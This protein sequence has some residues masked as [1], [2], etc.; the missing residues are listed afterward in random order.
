MTLDNLRQ[1]LGYALRGIRARPAFAAAVTV[2]LA[3]GIGANAAMFGIVDRLLFRP[4]PLLHD[5][6]TTHR[7][8]T[9]RQFR[10]SERPGGVSQYARYLGLV[11]WTTSFS[12]TAG[13]SVG[14]M[15]VGVGEAAREMQIGRVS[16]GFFGFFDAAPALGRFFTDAEDQPPAGTPVAVLGYTFWRTRYGGSRDVL[17]SVVQIGPTQYTII[18]VAPREFVGLWADRPPAAYIP[19]TS[20]AGASGV[21]LGNVNWWETY[22]WGWMNMIARRKPGVPVEAANADLSQALIKTYAAQRIEQPGTGPD[23]IL[24]PRAIAGSILAERGPT[25]SPTARVATWVG[26]VSVIVLLIACAN[27]ANLLL[28]RALHRRREIALRLA[29]GVSRARLVSQLLI[30]SVVLALMGGAAGILVAHWGGA[31]LRA[32]LLGSE[33]SGGLSDPRTVLFAAVAALAVGVLAGLAPV[34]Q[35]TRSDLAGDLKAGVREGT[36]GRSRTRV[37]LL[38]VQSALSVVLLIGAGL[39]V[40][41]LR[42]VRLV[43]LGF[44]TEPVVM[45]DLAMRGVRLDSAAYVALRGRLLEAAR[46]IPGVEN[47]SLRAAVPFWSSWSFGAPR[48]A[49]V[50]STNRFGQFDLNPVSAEHFATVG[51]RIL[52]GRG[53]EPSDVAGAPLAAVVSA[54]MA[55]VLWPGKDPLGE[56]MRIGSDTV[57]CTYVVGVAEDIKTRTLSPDSTFYYYLSVQQ[58]NPHIGGLFVRTAG[59]AGPM[60]ETVRKRLQQEMPGASYV[61]V[62]PMTDI[63]GPQMRSWRLGAT[64]FVAFGLLALVVAGVG[65]YSVIAY[66]VQQ[67]THELGVRMALGADAR[68]VARLVLL[69]GLRFAAFGVAAGAGLALLGGRYVADLLF[70]VSPRDPFVFIAVTATLGAVA[71]AA[72]WIPAVRAARVEPNVVLRSE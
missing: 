56:C 71:V 67:R 9:F 47:A 60:I 26:G 55:R 38:L 44:D 16:A 45:V 14:E 43:P 19:I 36:H 18:G 57:P 37:A 65:L 58:R 6:A 39:F 28:A 15:A 7:V 62:T 29:L 12:Q 32:G 69:G 4:P 17:D 30:E 2:T 66:N 72:S 48:V 42:N 13:W 68:A 53:I 5:P 22:G 35:A 64:M 49:G 11:R 61:T 27:V 25:S 3:L 41:S 1:D 40:R 50:D 46:G 20:Y 59:P 70:Q 52:R 10:G 63:V 33:A 23:S 21:R 8:Y 31:A 51:T 34:F 54:S 24:R